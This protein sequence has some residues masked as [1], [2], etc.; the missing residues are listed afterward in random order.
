[1]AIIDNSYLPSFSSLRLI[2]APCS[3]VTVFQ[4]RDTVNRSMV[5]TILSHH[6]LIT[7]NVVLTSRNVKVNSYNTSYNHRYNLCHNQPELF[8]ITLHFRVSNQNTICRALL[9]LACIP[10]SRLNFIL[11][12]LPRY[13][14][15]IIVLIC[16]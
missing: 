16:D 12:K 2:S 10:Y 9:T 3:V 13:P 14:S 7:S 5:S 6:S 1:M 4:V 15:S 11:S 8:V